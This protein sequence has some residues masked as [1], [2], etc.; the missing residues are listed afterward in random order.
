MSEA[1]KL[2]R[3]QGRPKGRGL[4]EPRSGEVSWNRTTRSVGIRPAHDWAYQRFRGPS[5]YDAHLTCAVA[6]LPLTCLVPAPRRCRE[7]APWLPPGLEARIECHPAVDEDA[8]AGD[9][10]GLIRGQPRDHAAD[11]LDLADPLVR[12]E[13][14]EVGIGL[15]RAPG[16]GVDRRADRA[17]AHAVDPD[18]VRRDLLGDRLHHQHHAAFGG[19]VI[20]VARPRDDLVHRADADDLAGGAGDLGAH[21]AA[22]ELLDRLA[23]AQEL[24]G[25]VDPDH[26]VPLL[27]RHLLEGRVLLQAG[28]VDQ[29]VDRAEFS[30][31]LGKHRLDLVLLADVS[32]MGVGVAALVADLGHDLLG[33]LALGGVVDHHVGAGPAEWHRHLRQRFIHAIFGHLGSPCRAADGPAVPSSQGS[34]RCPPRA[35]S[36][37][38]GALIRARWVKAWGKLPSASP[39]LPVSSAYRPTWL[40]KPSMRSKI[41]RASS[42]SGRWNRPARVSASTSQ[43]VQM[44]KV[45]SSPAK[46]SGLSTTW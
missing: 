24:A 45:P 10:I 8:G 30:Q 14:H 19:R 16:G 4:K 42:S 23:G 36:R 40:A 41:N 31:H 6:Q 46:P 44:L 27:E 32:L 21:A 3:L 25:E 35:R 11:V 29:D 39:R 15:G 20:D 1:T 2:K 7:R 17:R 9:V 43:K 5:R 33:R 34:Y 38:N 12:H 13:L 37:L 18:A 28:V 22:L 26:R